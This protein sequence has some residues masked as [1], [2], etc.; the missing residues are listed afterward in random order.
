MEPHG[1]GVDADALGRLGD[2]ERTFGRPQYGEDLAAARTG[3]LAAAR[4]GA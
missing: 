4:A 2:A 1:V 3:A